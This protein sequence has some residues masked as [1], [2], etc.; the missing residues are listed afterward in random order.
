MLL[1][2]RYTYNIVIP[3]YYYVYDFS[4]LMLTGHAYVTGVLMHAIRLAVIIS[5]KCISVECQE[6]IAFAR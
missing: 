1:K 5:L 6:E 3:V 2:H 4:P